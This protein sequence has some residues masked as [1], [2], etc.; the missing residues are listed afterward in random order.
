MVKPNS[1]QTIQFLLNEPEA[2]IVDVENT[3]EVETAKD[4]VQKSFQMMLDVMGK[5]EEEN[6]DYAWANY[7]NTTIQHLVPQFKAFSVSHVYTGGGAGIV[8]ATSGRHGASWRMVVELGDKPTAFG[9]YP[10]GQSGN[11]GSKYYKNFIPV[12]AEGK[13]LNFNLREESE[14]E[15]VLF[16]T[17]LK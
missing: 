17:T 8:N 14:A 6:G 15:G 10:G 4:H 7:K 13:Y 12:W 16:Q 5:W 3:S 9:V 1:Y 11:P 2:K